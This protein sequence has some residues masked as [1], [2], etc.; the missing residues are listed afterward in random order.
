MGRTMLSAV[1]EDALDPITSASAKPV[2]FGGYQL[3]EELGRGAVGVAYR[4]RQP[5]LGRDVALKVMVGAQFHGDAARKRFLAEAEIA[6]QLD[7]PNIVPVYEVGEDQGLPFFAMKLIEGPTLADWVRRQPQRLSPDAAARLVAKVATAVHHAH[8][9]GVLHR[10]VKPGN[11]LIAP[12]GEPHV[13]DFG[14]ARRLDADSLLTLSGAP[15]GTP[16]YM[17]PEQAAGK[18][19]ISV[20][21]DIWSLGAVLYE[22]LAGR[23]PFRGNTVPDLLRSIT[24]D[25]PPS[26]VSPGNRSKS[27]RWHELETVCRKCLDKDSAHR[28]S[29]AQA[30]AD[31]LHRWLRGEPLRARP[32]SSC[33]RLAKWIRR[34]PALAALSGLALTLFIIGVAGI[35]WQWR[36]ANHHALNAENA[37]QQTR[38]ALWQANFDRAHA[39]RTSRQMGQRFAALAAVK[40][41]AALRPDPRLR[42]EAVAA[43]AL[44]DFENTGPWHDL[45]PNTTHVAVDPAL[46]LYAASIFSNQVQIRRFA[47]GQLLSVLADGGLNAALQF[48]RDGTLLAVRTPTR[49]TVWELSTTSVVAR[50]PANQALTLSPDHQ[51]FARRSSTS[52]IVIQATRTGREVSR[53][54]Q[55]SASCLSFSPSGEWLAFQ[56]NQHVEVWSWREPQLRAQLN[57]P[58]G[59]VGMAWHPLE[60]A[61]AV[62]C[63]NGR[64]YLWDFGAEA[65]GAADSPVTESEKSTGRVRSL[66]GHT[67]EGVIPYFHP[68][69]EMLASTAWDGVLRVWDYGHEQPLL[70]SK[71]AGAL[72]FSA[73]G[74]WLA[75]RDATRIGRW[76]VGRS[77]ESRLLATVTGPGQSVSSL[78]FSPDSRFLAGIQH[79]RD[80]W[81][82]EAASGKRCVRMAHPGIKGLEF[83]STHVLLVTGGGGFALWTNRPPDSRWQSPIPN[84]SVV[85]GPNLQQ[86]IRC[87]SNGLVLRYPDSFELRQDA[88]TRKIVRGLD[89]Q[90]LSEAAS[91]PDGR[92]IA[93]GAWNNQGN[94]GGEL[95]LWSAE[96]DQAV[97]KMALGNCAPFFSPDGRWFVAGAVQGY[98]LCA[99]RGSP[100]AWPI[101]RTYERSAAGF[102]AGKAAFSG[103]GQLLALQPDERL[104]ALMNPETGE[105]LLRLTPLANSTTS[106]AMSPDGRWL[107][108]ST[109][110]GVQLWDL[111]ETRRRLGELGLDGR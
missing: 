101:V 77:S 49:D 24:D 90:F 12:D 11:I 36:R 74:H 20:A 80:I 94:F 67:R 45:P 37:L 17:S 33:E 95:R 105:E 85:V 97:R 19:D 75:V 111:Q 34:R 109:P 70:E 47:D 50:L 56:V 89:L 6:A 103:D 40:A 3:A 25:E 84:P 106:V 78:R 15:V 79:H 21:T 48:S 87:G 27:R 29:S 52:G 64:I 26:L 5:K 43:L 4:A 66:A 60:A 110:L 44:T 83:V 98:S 32:V 82:W 13:S 72:A 31:D 96:S 18:R 100:D 46:T 7:H 81:I 8:Q 73:D 14:L 30:L 55:G 9:R 107:A 71:A 92:W 61:L 38:D 51:C 68:A 58:A 86:T 88:E 10:D 54:A 102:N 69:G 28:Y 22:L 99:I 2:S 16:A 59:T 63:E 1:E 65:A 23:P 42:E 57:L 104:V 91:S 41:A 108:A 53:F 35:A 62:G 93:T 76:R 39:L